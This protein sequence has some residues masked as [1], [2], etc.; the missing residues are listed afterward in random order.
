MTLN[1]NRGL[2]IVPMLL[3]LLLL[4]LGPATAQRDA[5]FYNQQELNRGTQPVGYGATDPR[6]SGIS[7]E[8]S[9]DRPAAEPNSAASGKTCTGIVWTR[10][11]TID[12]ASGLVTAGPSQPNWVGHSATY[13]QLQSAGSGTWKATFPTGSTVTDIKMCGNSVCFVVHSVRENTTQQFSARCN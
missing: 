3:S 9:Y 8:S 12:F 5:L 11:F 1:L 7:T 2:Y 13:A 6:D 4:F 10:D